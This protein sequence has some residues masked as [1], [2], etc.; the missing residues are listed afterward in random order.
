MAVSVE[1]IQKADLEKLHNEVNQLRNHELLVCSFAIGIVGTAAA[2]LKN[3]PVVGLALLIIL[4][5]LFLWYY[6]L[7]DTRSRLT[8][9]LKA[10]KRS[11][12]ELLYRSFADGFPHSSQRTAGVVTFVAL[13]L[14]VPAITFHE[15]VTA[16][17]NGGS[18]D[19]LLPWF[20]A[21]L[22]VGLPYLVLVIYFGRL[23]KYTDRL[24]IYE[25][26]WLVLLN[27]D[28]NFPLGK[29]LE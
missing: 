26:R 24:A 27:G 3:G 1:D 19:F 17:L 9:F 10:T 16:I 18:V 13:G 22:V 12:W 11:Q 6:T 23:K 7:I 5:G 8:S 28:Q 4:L 14:F 2:E 25:K 20:V 29:E 15:G 21:Y